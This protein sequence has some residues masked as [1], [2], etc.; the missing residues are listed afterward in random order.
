MTA[1]ETTVATEQLLNLVGPLRLRNCPLTPTA[2]QEAFLRLCVP[3]VFFG[4]AAGGGKS[5]GLLMAA[6]Q[7]TD[8][9]G[10]DALLLRP[11]LAELVHPGGL[12]D[13]AHDWFAGTKASWSGEQRAW[14]FP[15]ATRSGAGGAAI[16]FGYLDGQKDLS[17]Y[18]GSSFSFLG[19]DELS[20]VDELSYRRMFRVVRQA[21]TAATLGHAPDGLTLA[22]VPVRIRAT[23]NPGGPNH[24]WIRNY[25]VDPET[26]N[27][28]VA[29]LPS[30]WNDNPHLD[31]A[32]YAKTLSHLPHAERERLINGD[33]TIADEGEIFRREWFELIDRSAIPENTR[34]VRYWDFAGSKPT[35]A[36][37]DPDYT[38]G[39]RLELDD[40]TGNYYITGIVR[41]RVHAGE[42]EQLVKATAEADGHAVGIVIEQEPAA[43]GAQLAH[44]YTAHVLRGFNVRTVIPTGSKEVR[45]QVAAAA[46]E[47]GLIKLITGPHSRDF[48]D[49]VAAFPNAAHDDCVDALAGAHAALSRHHPRPIRSW[50]P[51]G[52]T[53]LS[54]DGLIE[55]GLRR[56]YGTTFP[57]NYGF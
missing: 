2:R 48:L 51:Q 44:R 54:A 22:D 56:L 12:L 29:F 27:P 24:M 50:V 9:P 28:E 17:R 35:L 40:R 10:Y 43:S 5:I 7:Y 20:Q 25:F 14:R 41:R 6:S 31:L 49:E 18:A 30:R 3:E 4:G 21:S 23:S 53:N 39:L 32:E 46:A 45:A 19:F 15:A 52:T 16:W 36:N 38:V 8:V 26:R 11:T 13:L 42:V 1:L 34:A 47:N 57:A 37:P 33:W 55:A